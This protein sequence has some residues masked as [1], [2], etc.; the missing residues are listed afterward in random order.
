VPATGRADR[1]TLG[2]AAR[3]LAVGGSNTVGTFLLFVLLQQ[4]LTARV[5]YTIAYVAGL[6]YTTVMTP[7]FVFRGQVRLNA[8]VIFVVWYLCMYCVG[9]IVVH[10]TR[11]AWHS[12]WITALCTF[13][14]SAPLNFLVGRRLFGRLAPSAV[15]VEPDVL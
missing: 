10:Y 1:R 15:A 6:S 11:D 9:L 2:Q 14:V 5:A 8:V 13:A 4:L 3:F 7:R 12:S